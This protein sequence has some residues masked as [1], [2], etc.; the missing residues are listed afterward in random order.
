MS[1]KP[2]FLS[3]DCTLT[4]M[5]QR[6]RLPLAIAGLLLSAQTQAFL[7]TPASLVRQGY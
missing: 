6:A 7:P 1:L 5:S 4:T 3:V 2:N